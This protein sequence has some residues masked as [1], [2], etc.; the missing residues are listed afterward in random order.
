MVRP[1]AGSRR[2][3]SAPVGG[4]YLGVSQLYKPTKNSSDSLQKE[5]APGKQ[6]NTR[7]GRSEEVGCAYS[8]SSILER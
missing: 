4:V 2:T 6:G 1:V 3:Q 7:K 8:R 5:P